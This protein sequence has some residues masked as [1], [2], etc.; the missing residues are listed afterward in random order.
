[1][2]GGIVRSGTAL[3]AGMWAAG[4]AVGRYCPVEPSR[5]TRWFSSVSGIDQVCDVV[6]PFAPVLSEVAG[7]IEGV[8]SS[9][10]ESLPSQV[11]SGAAILLGAGLCYRNQKFLKRYLPFMGL[12]GGMISGIDARLS[13]TGAL[14][15]LSSKS[16]E[17]CRSG[18]SDPLLKEVNDFKQW[19]IKNLSLLTAALPMVVKIL[20]DAVRSGNPGGV[21][22]RLQEATKNN[23]TKEQVIALAL[24][25]TLGLGNRLYA[26]H[27]GLSSETFD[28]SGHVMLKTLLAEFLSLSITQGK[29]LGE[30]SLARAYALINS[31][32][33]GVLIHNTVRACH[34]VSE[35][36]AGLGWG[37]G[38]VG[39]GKAIGSLIGD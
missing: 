13:D 38:I 11:A 9:A 26:P 32:M 33:D 12:L 10:I 36:V 1:M 19:E 29:L 23:L 31:L 17:L 34:T 22:T 6:K 27:L 18:F 4:K 7:K 39:L 16:K 2:F 35:A 5:W 25:V 37:L 30:S 15:Y 28:A 21:L 8:V 3:A 14:R 20:V 24:I